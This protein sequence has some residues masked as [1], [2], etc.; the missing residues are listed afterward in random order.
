MYHASKRRTGR[1]YKHT[2]IEP[3]KRQAV[4]HNNY[5]MQRIYVHVVFAQNSKENFVNNEVRFATKRN[6]VHTNS[7]NTKNAFIKKTHP[8]QVDDK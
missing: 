5:R 8:L 7:L 6:N 1:I 4:R 3:C 2:E